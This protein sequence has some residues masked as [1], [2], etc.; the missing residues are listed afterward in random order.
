MKIGL[1]NACTPEEE[2][3]FQTLEYD[4]FRGFI[5]LVPNEIELHDYRITEGDFPVNPAECD[6]YIITGSPAGAYDT[7]PW[8]P[9]LIDFIRET[10]GAGIKIVG[11][12]FGHQVLAHALGGEAQKSEKGWG[13]G[14][15]QFQIQTENRPS[16][17]TLPADSGVCNLYFCHQDQ[18]VSLP[19]NATRLAGSEFCPNAMFA[20][21]DQVLGMQ[22][23]P[24]FTRKTMDVTVDYFNGKLDDGFMKEV[25]ET[26]QNGTGPDAVV[27]AQWVVSFLSE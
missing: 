17:L 26:Y 24:E 20:I 7:L 6:G 10:Y 15:R 16:W 14:L 3:E 1:L 4:N 5:D 9:K 21:G 22:G 25:T 19:Q 12:C 23:H 11:M 27:A 18:V 13:M 8:I 2:I